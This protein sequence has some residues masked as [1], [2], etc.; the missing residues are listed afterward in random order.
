MSTALSEELKLIVS[1][2]EGGDPTQWEIESNFGEL[3]NVPFVDRYVRFGGY[4]GPYNP[5]L[6]AAAP[7]LL[8]A[9]KRSV[10][11]LEECSDCLDSYRIGQLEAARAAIAK[12]EGRAE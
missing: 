2:P 11:A 6:F 7:D 4:F 10:V 9:L 5:A 8:A 3:E 1:K 12:A